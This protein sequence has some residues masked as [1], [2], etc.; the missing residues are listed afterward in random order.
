MTSDRYIPALRF[1]ALTRF[2]DPFI[3]L[4][5]PERRFKRRLLE[6]AAPEPGQRI[7]DV[8][9]GTGTL[10]ILAASA[11]PKA[12]VIGLDADP[13][14]LT[15]ARHKAEAG[16]AEVRFDQGF[17]TE[18]PYEDESLDLVLSTLF[19]HHLAGADKRRTA[20]EIARVLR[21]GGELHV[22]DWGRPADP[23]MRI[24]F[25]S[26]RIFDGLDQTRDNVAGALTDIFAGGGLEEATETDRMRTAFGTLALYRA[27]KPLDLSPTL[28]RE[29]D[30]TR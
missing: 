23:L 2:F 30:E 10:A 25:S 3:R 29:G 19:F 15:R 11:Q 13:E 22:A 27:R 8:G 6:Q 24:L 28:P 16:G 26:V 4:A 18:L 14:I 1:S 20:S 5:L 21:A 7:L 9:C 12:E 17:S